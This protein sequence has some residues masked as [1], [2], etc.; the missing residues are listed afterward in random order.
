[1]KV[2]RYTRNDIPVILDLI[3]ESISQTIY[4][5]IKMDGTKMTDILVGNENNILFHGNVVEDD[6]GKI[7]GCFCATLGSRMW[8]KEVFAFDQLF[9]VKEGQRNARV[10]TSLVAAYRDWAKERKV[11]KAFLANSMGLNVETFARL[12]KSLGFEQVGSIH[13]MEIE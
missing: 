6:D 13:Q 12:A 9:Y 11:R 10:A 5:D 1:M 4:K 3:A 7:I 2:R 8:T